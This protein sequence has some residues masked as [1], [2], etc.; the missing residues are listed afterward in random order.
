MMTLGEK[1][2]QMR[3][4]LTAIVTFLNKDESYSMALQAQGA[5]ESVAE[6]SNT[7]ADLG[8]DELDWPGVDEKG[9]TP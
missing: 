8:V 2:D 6:L 7:A 4:D 9:Q 1:L 5:L 3:G